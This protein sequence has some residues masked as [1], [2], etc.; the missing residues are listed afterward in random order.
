MGHAPRSIVRRRAVALVLCEA[1]AVVAA[2][3]RVHEAVAKCLG[4]DGRRRNGGYAAVAA[5]DGPL[6]RQV[7]VAR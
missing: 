7:S 1:V 4:K 6:C 5:D 3:E 2:V